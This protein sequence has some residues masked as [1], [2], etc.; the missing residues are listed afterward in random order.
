MKKMNEKKRKEEKKY[1]FYHGRAQIDTN[2]LGHG[3]FTTTVL[4][5]DDTCMGHG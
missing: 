2:Y 4:D 1:F 3:H 5:S